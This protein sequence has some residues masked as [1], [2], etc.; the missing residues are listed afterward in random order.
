MQSL[1]EKALGS[2]EPNSRAGQITTQDGQHTSVLETKLT[3]ELDPHGR[4]VVAAA[5]RSASGETT[6][7]VVNE[8]YR[9]ASAQ[10]E[11]SPLSK[12]LRRYQVTTADRD[13][14]FAPVSATV[15]PASFEDLLPALSI[16]VYTTYDLR[17]D[18]PG[19]VN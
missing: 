5:L 8:S 2:N 17:D 14:D 4:Q 18:E 13:R 12:P 6:V 3:G 1:A 15:R 16:T 7:L 10:V 9:A 19:V 11:V